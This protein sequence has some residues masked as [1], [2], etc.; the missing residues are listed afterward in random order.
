MISARPEGFEPP[1]RGFEGDGTVAQSEGLRG[2]AT[3]PGS[4]GVDRDPACFSLRQDDSSRNVTEDNGCGSDGSNRTE[5]GARTQA[6]PRVD[7]IGHYVPSRET[8]PWTSSAEVARAP[9]SVRD[10]ERAIVAATL[11]GRHET[12][13]LLADILR[14]RLPGE[15]ANFVRIDQGRRR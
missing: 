6:A 12:A 4:V 8:P 13:D 7:P 10:L 2:V 11:A 14:G 15:R 5:S 1:T 3:Q 9:D